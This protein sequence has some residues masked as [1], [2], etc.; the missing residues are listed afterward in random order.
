MYTIEKTKHETGKAK[1]DD[2][3]CLSLRSVCLTCGVEITRDVPGHAAAAFTA[4][5]F[6]REHSHA[7]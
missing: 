3:R 5:A 2:P 4:K 6:A 7:G 1:R